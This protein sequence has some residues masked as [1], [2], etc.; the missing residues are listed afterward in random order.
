MRS[1]T[2]YSNSEDCG[3]RGFRPALRLWSA[4][5]LGAVRAEASVSAPGP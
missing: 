2:P 5:R 1:T 3:Q 4:G